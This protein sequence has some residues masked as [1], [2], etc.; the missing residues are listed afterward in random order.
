MEE[1][2]PPAPQSKHR[3][4]L[5]VVLIVVCLGLVA[6]YLWGLP[7]YQ[8]LQG[9]GGPAPTASGLAEPSPNPSSFPVLLAS[10]D[11]SASPSAGNLDLMIDRNGLS[12]ATVVLQTSQGVVKFKFY[13]T[14]APNTVQRVAS[15]M[16]QGFYNGLIFHRVIPGFIVQTGSPDGSDQGGSGQKIAPEFSRRTH[17][18]GTVAMARG[19]DVNSAD[20]QFYI[21]LS[22]QPHLDRDYTIFG[23]VV[24]GLEV[25]KGLK[26][27]DKILSVTIE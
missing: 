10:P 24:E 12:K 26:V 13:P 6:G 7:W 4:T 20:S 27:G 22:P 21:T 15:L 1:M 25:V 18:A 9:D 11:A 23:M 19:K 2:K 17:V 5:M 8:G 14:E 3:L 16:Q